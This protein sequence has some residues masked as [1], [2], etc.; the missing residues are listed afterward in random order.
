MTAA[1]RSESLAAAASPA[2]EVAQPQLSVVIPS[3]DRVGTLLRCVEAVLCQE[4]R[5][6][7]EI[8]IVDDGRRQRVPAIPDERVRVVQGPRKGPA[9]ARNRG[10]AAARASIVCFT[11]DDTIPSPIWLEAAAVALE[12]QPGAVGVEGPTQCEPYDPLYTVGPRND[13]PGA[14]WTCNVAYR[15][16]DLVGVGA[17]DEG[18][19]HP[20][21]EDRDLA[22]RIGSRGPITFSRAMCVSH[23]PRP[24]LLADV[25]RYSG[26]LDSEWRLYRK[27]PV[28][29]PR[30]PMRWAPVIE[31]GRRWQR[32]LRAEARS[33]RNPRRIARA[34]ALG[35]VATAGAFRT[36]LLRWP[37]NAP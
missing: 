19:P 25:V 13:L 35:L 8:V 7:F 21:C 27:H 11:D 22:E 36:A 26:W 20:F 12:G 37:G 4:T 1:P 16:A 32:I 23:P 14:R 28:L 5:R 29:S 30:W 18:F 15:R 9:A 6:P 31:T 33:P 24:L 17:F 34:A 10:I 3:C 2:D